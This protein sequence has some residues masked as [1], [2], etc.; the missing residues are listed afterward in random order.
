LLADL[1]ADMDPKLAASV[2]LPQIEHGHLG[3]V[4]PVLN[5]RPQPLVCFE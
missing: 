1:W 2:S 4:A 3:D 5:E